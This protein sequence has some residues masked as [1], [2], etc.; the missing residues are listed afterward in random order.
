MST[1][2]FTLYFDGNCPF[3]RAGV[4]RLAGWD[5]RQQLAFVDIA[6]PGF[7]AAQ[8][9]CKLADV[10][11]ELYVRTGDGRLLKGLAGIT[12]VYAAVGQGWRVAWMRWPLLRRVM[13]ALYLLF[14]RRFTS[15]SVLT[16]ASRSV[17][18]CSAPRSRRWAYSM[19]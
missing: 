2:A 14:A 13:N 8:L 5:K 3:C 10:N 1:P 4:A 19:R 15:R 16:S 11:R 18:R 9:G 7:D 17:I 6:R 12:A